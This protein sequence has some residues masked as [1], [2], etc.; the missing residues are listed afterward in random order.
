MDPHRTASAFW[1]AEVLVDPKGYG[2]TDKEHSLSVALP[3]A[4]TVPHP[5][6]FPVALILTLHTTAHTGAAAMHC[7]AHHLQQRSS[8][9]T[10]CSSSPVNGQD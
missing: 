2:D 8:F 4:I 5:T 1:G 6:Y 10:C 7:A 3:L 9:G